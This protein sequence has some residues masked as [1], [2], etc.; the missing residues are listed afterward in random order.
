MSDIAHGLMGVVITESRLSRVNGEKGELVISGYPIEEIAPKASFE[1]M[2]FLLWND[3]LPMLTELEE[4]KAEMIPARPMHDATRMLLK[5]AAE[6]SLSPMDALR[7]AVDTLS[8]QDNDQYDQSRQANH[9]RGLMIIASMPTIVASYWRLLNSLEPIDPDP[10]LAHAAN[11]L[12][13][14]T[15]EKP[16]PLK[17]RAMETYLTTAVD[18]GMNASTFSARV[19]ISTRSDM[20]S[21][22]IGAIGALK[23]PLHGGAPGPALDMVYAFRESAD[24]SGRSLADEADD[25]ARATIKAGGRI[26]GFGH[27]VYKAHDPRVDVF[28][29]A[30]EKLYRRSGNY[31]LYQDARAAEKII[32]Q[33]LIELKPGRQI[34]TNVEYY[35]A[36]LLNG[37]GLSKELFTPTFAVS[38]VAG[39]TANVLEQIDEDRLMRPRA[40]YI[41]AIGR[42]WTPISERV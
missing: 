33:V 12:Y 30:V 28:A 14:L 20:Y 29:G 19:I 25:W 13:M 15:G 36:L 42:K 18:H 3:R 11:Y 38:R 17:A 5:M 24:K 26:M 27:R 40:A 34:K 6:R 16:D 9:R 2:I 7:M 4:L 39:W 8:L 22:I 32:L 41:G 21:A 37:V 31:Q 35:T 1:E 23:G 10:E